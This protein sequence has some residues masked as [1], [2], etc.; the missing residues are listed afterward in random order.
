MPPAPAVEPTAAK[1]AVVLFAG[2]FASGRA[3]LMVATVSSFFRIGSLPAMSC[4]RSARPLV[5]PFHAFTQP[6]KSF[7]SAN[8][9]RFFHDQNAAQISGCISSC[10]AIVGVVTTGRPVRRS[11]AAYPSLPVH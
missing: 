5:P 9:F 10:E 7:A 11:R 8:R 2:S 1:A 6:R 3:G 4:W